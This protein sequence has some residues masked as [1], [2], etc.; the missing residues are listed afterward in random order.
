MLHTFKFKIYAADGSAYICDSVA[1]TLRVWDNTRARRGGVKFTHVEYSR[2]G[3]NG[4]AGAWYPVGIEE[5]REHDI[6]HIYEIDSR[7]DGCRKLVVI[8]AATLCLCASLV[9]WLWFTN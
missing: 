2:V 1:S 8:I 7:N 6:A 9:G 5:L 3:A 4:R